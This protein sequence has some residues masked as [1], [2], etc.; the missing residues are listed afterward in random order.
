MKIS[1]L[2]AVLILITFLSN[3]QSTTKAVYFAQTHVVKPD[4]KVP[5]V[6]QTFKLISNR[7]SL[8]KVHII[9]PNREASPEVRVKLDLND[10]ITYFIRPSNF[11]SFF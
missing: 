1:F 10:A 8:I 6:N 9:S 5:L 11:T 7:A 2:S 3:A 4:Y